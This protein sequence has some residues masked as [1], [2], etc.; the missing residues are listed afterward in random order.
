MEEKALIFFKPDEFGR[1]KEING[2][3]DVR[4]RLFELGLRRG[5]RI[6]IVKNDIGPLIV[7]VSGCKMA[8]GRGLASKIILHN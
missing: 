4:K 2:C 5:A 7:N 8:L 6:R 1:I 3:A